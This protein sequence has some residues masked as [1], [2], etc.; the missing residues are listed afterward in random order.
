MQIQAAD[1][2]AFLKTPVESWRLPTLEVGKGELA[3]PDTR[4]RCL[5]SC[6]QLMGT[7][8][9]HGVT[10]DLC[11]GCGTVWLDGGELALILK[12]YEDPESPENSPIW[13]ILDF[14]V[15]LGWF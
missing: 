15:P 2:K 6:G 4:A 7:K 12:R 3:G 14:L 10:I 13:C 11:K 1:L 9:R 5:C 8:K